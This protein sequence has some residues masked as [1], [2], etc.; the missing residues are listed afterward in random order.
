MILLKDSKFLE[1]HLIMDYSLLLGVHL[2]DGTDAPGGNANFG[3][4]AVR[5]ANQEQEEEGKYAEPG[6]A[7]DGTKRRG[8]S[9]LWERSKS[10]FSKKGKVSLPLI[11]PGEPIAGA[12]GDTFFMGVIDILQPYNVRKKLETRLKSIPYKKGTISCVHP[13]LYAK[14]FLNFMESV[15]VP[16]EKVQERPGLVDKS[17]KSK[18]RWPFRKKK[19]KNARG[20]IYDEDKGFEESE[21]QD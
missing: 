13:S 8:L 6:P 4:K 9:A 10:I 21:E 1:K 18:R 12:N 16:L 17:K 5:F 7:R 15:V 19:N 3:G 20:Y 14:R 2:N 11:R